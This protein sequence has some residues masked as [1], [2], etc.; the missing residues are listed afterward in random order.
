MNYGARSTALDEAQ[1]L[2]AERDDF[3][4]WAEGLL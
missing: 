3:A 4:S 1:R 2:L